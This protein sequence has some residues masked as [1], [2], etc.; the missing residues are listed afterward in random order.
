MLDSTYEN[1][2][3]TLRIESDR[4]IMLKSWCGKLVPVS[5][6]PFTE[7]GLMAGVQTGEKYSGEVSLRLVTNF[8][9]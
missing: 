5:M 1:V 6:T 4:V 2:P 8:H 3:M 9:P 7:T